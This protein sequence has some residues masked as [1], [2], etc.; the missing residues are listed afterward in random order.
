MDTFLLGYER[1]GKI[2]KGRSSTLLIP[3]VSPPVKANFASESPKFFV[4]PGRDWVLGTGD[5]L[6]LG[7]G[8]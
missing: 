5:W 4:F 6:V 1:K 8:D 2:L 7:T 3:R